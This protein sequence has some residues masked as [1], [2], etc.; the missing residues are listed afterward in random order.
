MTYCCENIRK[1]S[2]LIVRAAGIL[3]WNEDFGAGDAFLGV[4]TLGISSNIKQAGDLKEAQ[5]RMNRAHNTLVD[6][7]RAINACNCE[8]ESR[9]KYN[10][11]VDEF[12]KLS[13]N[14]VTKESAEKV[15]N[16][17]KKNVADY[18]EL[19]GN[20]KVLAEKKQKYTR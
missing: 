20:Y 2:E 17:Y 13:R 3:D 6:A 18:N 4:F 12:N 1:G 16:E 14:S 19:I 5:N 7:L 15:Q 8:N 10:K 11:L 9:V